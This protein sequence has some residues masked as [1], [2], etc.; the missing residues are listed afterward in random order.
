MGSQFS[1]I[2]GENMKKVTSLAF[3]ALLGLSVATT[4]AVADA[5]IGQKVYSQVFKDKCGMTGTKF[6]ASHTQDEWQDLLDSGKFA[7]EMAGMC[8]G[9][10]VPEKFVPHLFDFAHMY[11]SDSGNVPSC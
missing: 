5:A 2:I 7:E 11:A 8:G 1:K 4:A 9:T 10:A 6:A 3:A